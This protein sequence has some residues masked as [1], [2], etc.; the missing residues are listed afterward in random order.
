VNRGDIVVTAGWHSGPL[1]DIYPRGIPIGV[2][3][4]VS[5]LDIDLYKRVEIE[6]FAQFG[7]L[8]SVI[9]LVPAAKPQ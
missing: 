6:P 9:I 4:S 2:V 7:S 3:T 8:E 1:S 5:Q